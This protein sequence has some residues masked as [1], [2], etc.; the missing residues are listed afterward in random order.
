MKKTET[1]MEEKKKTKIVGTGYSSR[2]K[3][4]EGTVTK[5]FPKRIVIEFERTIYVKK[6]ERYSRS[7]TKLHA[8]VPQS[9]EDLIQVGDYVKIQECRPLSKIIHFVVIEKI[10][11]VLENTEAKKLVKG[12]KRKR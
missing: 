2:G 10:R 8:R 4:F 6:F 12:G 7:K 5:K 9:M 3:T 1:K 11:D